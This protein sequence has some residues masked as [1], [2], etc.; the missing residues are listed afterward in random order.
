[1]QATITAN[2]VK[3]CGP[4][5]V[6]FTDNTPN[7]VSYSWDFGNGNTSTLATP[8]AIYVSP[9]KYTVRLRVIDNAGT[10]IDFTETDFI[11]VFEPPLVKFTVSRRKFCLND[12]CAFL[13]QCSAGEAPIKT[14]SWDPGEGTLFSG[15]NPI[16]KYSTA[17]FKNVTLVAT[18]QNGCSADLKIASFVQVYALP[19]SEFAMDTSISCKKPVNVQFTPFA[20][21]GIA[22]YSWDFGNGK[23]STSKFPNTVYSK[24][25]KYKVQLTTTSLNNCKNTFILNNAVSVDSVVVNFDA[26]KTTICDLNTDLKFQNLSNV[27]QGYTWQWSLGDGATENNFDCNHIY[28]QAGIYNVSLKVTGPNCN[29]KKTKNNFIYVFDKPQVKFSFNDSGACKYPYKITFAAAANISAI[30]N[31]DFGDNSTIAAGKNVAHLYGNK[32]SNIVKLMVKG[33]NGCNVDTSFLVHRH[34]ISSIIDGKRGGCVPYSGEYNFKEIFSSSPIK[35]TYWKFNNKIDS[36]ATTKLSIIDTGYFQLIGFTM[37]SKGCLDSNKFHITTGKKYRPSLTF[38]KHKLCLQEDITCYLNSN[39]IPKT[40]AYYLN[41]RESDTSFRDSVTFKFF[42]AQGMVLPIL[43]TTHNLCTDTFSLKDTLTVNSPRVGYDFGSL[44]CK[45]PDSLFIINNTSTYTKF[46]WSASPAAVYQ[47]NDTMLVSTKSIQSITLKMFA[48]NDST[49]CEDSIKTV[50]KLNP[51]IPKALARMEVV[52]A[53]KPA[54]LILSDEGSEG[55]TLKWEL[56]NNDSTKNFNFAYLPKKYGTYKFKRIA[57]NNFGFQNCA[58]T[59]TFTFNYSE[60]KTGHTI[61]PTNTCSPAK[62]V[63][64]DSNYN[65]V[66]NAYWKI[67]DSII[68]STSNN[69]SKTIYYPFVK[70]PSKYYFTATN[71]DGSC[72]KTDSGYLTITGPQID[73]TNFFF[74]TCKLTKLQLSVKKLNPFA[75]KNVSWTI[76]DTFNATGTST[77]FTVYDTR[78]VK[79]QL[80]VTD[81]NDCSSTLTKYFFTRMFKPDVKFGTDIKSALCPP[82]NIRFFDSSTALNGNVISWLWDFGDGGTSNLKNPVHTYNL[83]GYYNISLQVKSILGCFATK[84]FTNFIKING[85]SGKIMLSNNQGCSPLKVGFATDVQNLKEIHW[86]YGDGTEGY[87]QNQF[88]VFNDSG[89]FTPSAILEDSAG[90]KLGITTTTKIIN[91]KSPV[92]KLIQTAFCENDSLRFED[93]SNYYNNP[94]LNKY[95]YFNSANSNKST[96]SVKPNRLNNQLQFIAIGNF[97]CNDTLNFEPKISSVKAAFSLAK[98]KFCLGDTSLLISTSQSDTTIVKNDWW[99]NNIY[100]TGNKINLAFNKIGR[101]NLKHYTQNALGCADSL[102]TLNALLVGDTSIPKSIEPILIS[103]KQSDNYQFI[104]NKS[105]DTFFENYKLLISDKS[106]YWTTHNST[107]ISDT[108]LIINLPNQLH[109]R[110]CFRVLQT[111]FCQRSSDSTATLEHC[112]ILLNE[113]TDSNK[114]TLKFTPYFGNTPVSYQLTRFN[115]TS[116]VQD[117]LIL[118]NPTDSVYYDTDIHCNNNYAYQVSANFNSNTFSSESNIRATQIKYRGIPSQP[119]IQYVT[120]NAN[121]VEL[122][123][124]TLN[125]TKNDIVEYQIYKVINGNASSWKNS[126]GKQLNFT[127]PNLNIQ[128]QIYSYT[129]IS[130]NSCGTKSSASLLS[131]S[132][133]CNVMPDSI[134]KDQLNIHW[135]AYRYWPG[136]VKQYTVQI[137][138]NNRGFRSFHTT[139]DTMYRFALNSNPCGN[140]LTFRIIAESNVNNPFSDTQSQKSISNIAGISQPPLVYIPNTFTPN[141]DKLNDHFFPSCYWIKSYSLKIYNRWGEKI[142]DN[143]GCE[144]KWDG[145]INGQAAPF[146]VYAYRIEVVG[147][148][149]K[150]MYYRG[151]VLLLK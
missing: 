107:N 60:P 93:Q 89:D 74:Y 146:G 37:N 10:I 59:Q 140:N 113:Q 104:F 13:Q 99:I 39:N 76:D 114:V 55:N 138:E 101:V 126:N 73:I 127:D 141:N 79:V 24:F 145:K 66:R 8:S 151:E 4:L 148:N 1:M 92:A 121:A 147:M 63:L 102:L 78:T 18:D 69:N 61:T 135:N 82:S 6:T 136:G 97:G 77:E 95:T 2:V 20:T 19:L 128:N 46:R 134:N 130:T 41:W 112:S 90:C 62:L 75:L 44:L 142:F 129:V 32:D 38:N 72:T 98:T 36:G 139:N 94:Q 109:T 65:S 29:Y 111:N 31:W 103:N 57:Q 5:S 116:N 120:T 49:G 106:K 14:Y 9:G 51:I 28:F 110:Q 86:D 43:Y 53:C 26:S 54:K 64:Y 45:K 108:N 115:K 105:K 48:K 12:T 125:F 150:K 40:T 15:A 118:L 133:L 30:F 23:T 33:G 85:P 144:A 50:I 83:P 88:H 17:G 143:N 52:S 119:F 96:Y 132:I 80:T 123:I 58:D 91:K 27:N 124:D 67:N 100:Y 47:T 42:R 81:S 68:N 122:K 35:K 70:N 3:G 25:G 117:K 34:Y 71:D 149:N 131:N 84:T 11:H 16:V 21:T 137:N 22:S 87:G 7:V 56:P